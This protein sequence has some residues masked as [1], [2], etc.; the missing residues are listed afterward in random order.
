MTTLRVLIVGGYGTFGGRL[1]QL[2]RDE[3]RLTLLIVGRSLAKAE[4]FCH[5]LGGAVQTVPARFDREAD[6][7]QQLA[8]L[9]PAV[10]V[11]ASG[12]F[13]QYGERPYRLLEACLAAGIHYLD[14]A[15]G[16]AFVDGVAQFDASA[17][18]RGLVMLSGVSTFPALSSIVIHALAEGM[19]TVTDILAGA[20]PSP[21]A[22]VGLNVI[23]AIASYAGKP[24]PLV[25][26]G[27]PAE[28]MALVESRFYVVAPPGRLPLRATHFSL[29]DVPDLR[30]L[31]PRRP[32]L[33]SIWMGAGPTPELLHRL[34]N[35]LALLVR[36]RLLPTL[37]PLAR[38]FHWSI[39]VLV[40]G[41][42]RGGM[43]VELAGLRNGRPC[44][45]SWHMVAEKDDGPMIPAM[46]MEALLRDMVEGRLPTA[47]ARPAVEELTLAEVE[48]RFAR[49]QIYAGIRNDDPDTLAGQPLYQRLLGN[50]WPSLPPTVRALHDLSAP[51]RF[52]GTA[53]VERGS[54]P[55][56]RLVAWLFGFP[57]ATPETPLA[58]EFSLADGVERWQRDFAGQ[59][60][61]SHQFEGKGHNSRLLCERFGPF[62][63][64]MA[65]LLEGDVMRLVVR[66]WTAVGLPLPIALAPFGESYETEKDGRFHFHVEICLPLI[67]LLVR[68]VGWLV[69]EDVAG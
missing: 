17:R 41:E 27:Q 56:A 45:R 19:D 66:R 35:L 2:L 69:A 44:V 22:G 14:F 60:F 9:K 6:L 5:Q 21:F 8:A 68:Y 12:P 38:L 46:V 61:H 34:L 57:L 65:L 40:W 42:H 49:W 23:R 25:R 54:N 29:V 13:Q 62:V 7:P 58:V 24:L 55:L 43:F 15:D 51:A 31:P 1:A 37:A 16:A 50:A 48:Q 33:Q 53:R 52:T 39:N 20:A 63:F 18:E 32:G 67:G 26:I 30:V 28:G 36:W 11:D 59:R 47:G 10:V 64:A 4:A 3:P